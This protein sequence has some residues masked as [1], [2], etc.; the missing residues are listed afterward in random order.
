MW[1]CLSIEKLPVFTEHLCTMQ[2]QSHVFG[3]CAWPVAARQA[4]LATQATGRWGAFL[5]FD[6]LIERLESGMGQTVA[7]TGL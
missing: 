5:D 7:A 4:L 6:H 2:P 1:L 3:A